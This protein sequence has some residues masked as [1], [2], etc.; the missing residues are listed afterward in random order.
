MTLN[1]NLHC[2]SENVHCLVYLLEIQDLENNFVV[3]A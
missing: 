1:C 3:V 2:V